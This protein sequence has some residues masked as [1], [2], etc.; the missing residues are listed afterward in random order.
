MPYPVA[1]CRGRRPATTQRGDGAWSASIAL[2]VAIA[3]CGPSA[4]SASPLPASLGPE[5]VILLTAGRDG[6]GCP[7]N[8]VEGQLVFE[9]TAGSAI[10]VDGISKLIRWPYGYAGRRYATEVDILDQT[11]T[12]VARTGT[13]IRLGGG[14]S[15]TGTWLACPGPVT[16]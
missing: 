8:V 6:V 4:S 5:T 12:V 16:K 1:T 9:S 15:E 3:G 11:G 14:E 10:I 13:R 7:A 2:L